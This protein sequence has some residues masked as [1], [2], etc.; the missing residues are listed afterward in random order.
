M[1][2]FHHK[3]VVITGAGSGMG[4]AYAMTFAALGAKLALNDFDPISLEATVRILNAQGHTEVLPQA[5]DVGNRMAM[6]EF[7]QA[8]KER[9]GGAHVVINNAGI[10]GS[11]L[12]AWH[13]TPADYERI[14]RVNFFGV[15]NGTLAFLPQ[16]QARNEGAIVNVSS[17]MGLIG[18]P[19]Q[20]DYCASKF[21][22][23]GFTEALMVELHDSPI[24]VHLVHP[25]GVAT[26]IARK[27]HSQAFAQRYLTT[28]PEDVAKRV[29]EGIRKGQA[30]II[31]GQDAFKTWVGSNLLPH[32][33]LTAIVWRE[34]RPTLDKAAYKWM[35]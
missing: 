19:S 13:T 31:C 34:I 30:K 18:S 16:L 29:V 10:E 9:F 21:A 7:A 24:S 23:R 12:P 2:D 1:K 35:R 32:K 26:N 20:S 25:G 6:D 14:M 15:V 5:F 22:V 4:R 33:W 11:A 8:V 3:V 28:P 17:I 27:P